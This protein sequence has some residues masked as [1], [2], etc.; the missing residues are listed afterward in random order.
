MTTSTRVW[1]SNSEGVTV[2]SAF[3][4]GTNQ[5][6]GIPNTFSA[7]VTASRTTSSIG[8]EHQTSIFACLCPS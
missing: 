1:I 3:N 6:G 7:G 8:H 4:Q 2:T 5:S